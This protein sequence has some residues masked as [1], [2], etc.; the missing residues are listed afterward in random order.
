MKPKGKPTHLLV[1]TELF[2][3]RKVV[4]KKRPLPQAMRR[5]MFKAT[6]GPGFVCPICRE[7]FRLEYGTY[8]RRRQAF[9]PAQYYCKDCF[10]AHNLVK[11]N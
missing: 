3:E 4:S 9:S 5:E 10:A 8:A 7:R 6:D 1:T 2:W 11:E